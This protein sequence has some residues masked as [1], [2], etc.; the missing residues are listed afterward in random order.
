MDQTPPL[1][2]PGRRPGPFCANLTQK[3]HIWSV[4]CATVVG[5]QCDVAQSS[6]GVFHVLTDVLYGILC[7]FRA[8]L[9]T[10]LKPIIALNPQS[11]TNLRASP[12]PTNTRKI[13]ASKA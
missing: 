13:K 11:K 4:G 5:I 6:G 3:S 9:T 8:A 10:G 7:R 2:H 12:E 1:P